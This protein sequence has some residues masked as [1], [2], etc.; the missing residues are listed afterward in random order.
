[1]GLVSD[2]GVHS[3][4]E[5]LYAL[6]K[7]AKRYNVEKVYVHAFIDGRDVE[8][9]SALKFIRPL[10][11]QLKK[12]DKNW[13]IATVTGRYYS[14]DRDN[15]WNREHKAYDA[16]VNGTAKVYSSAEKAVMANYRKGIETFGRKGF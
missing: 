8:P 2:A 5:H 6:L 7:L 15:R 10:E 13:K 16:I 14:M 4:I 3:H 11:K 9:K 1:M 12:L